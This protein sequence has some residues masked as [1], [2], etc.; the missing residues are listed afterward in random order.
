MNLKD[1]KV[2]IIIF[3]ILVVLAGTYFWYTSLYQPML[4]Q[5]EEKSEELQQLKDRLEIAKL[6][7]ARRVSLQQEYENLQEQ[8]QVVETLLPKERDMSNFIKQL[9][10]IKGKVDATIERVSPLEAESVDFYTKNPYEI[11]ML[12]TYHGLGQFLSHVANLPIIVDVSLLDMTAIPRPEEEEGEKL[13][14]RPSI[15]SRMVL[16]TYSLVEDVSLGKEADE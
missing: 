14:L 10:R 7:A 8:W 6:Q 11:E 12:T 4:A 13:T 5:V 9:H 3:L 15:S 1:T 16:T 2:Q